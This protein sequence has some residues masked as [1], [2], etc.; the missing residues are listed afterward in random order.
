M[1]HET[2]TSRLTTHPLLLPSCF[3]QHTACLCDAVIA[4]LKVPLSFQ[5]YFF[6][7]LQSTS[8][9]V[10]SQLAAWTSLFDALSKCR[11]QHC[12]HPFC[13]LTAVCA[14]V[15][16]VPAGHLPLAPDSERAN[17]CAEHSAADPEGGGG[18]AARLHPRTVQE[19]PVCVPQCHFCSPDQ[20]G[21]RLQGK[22]CG[23]RPVI[24]H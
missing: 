6:Q 19:D 22:E 23:L 11:F 12:R 1:Q 13:L 21:T 16:V 3:A 10:T 14:C 2:V 24:T 15:T 4:L 17:P 20:G 9:K 18:G 5:R 8:I 7:K